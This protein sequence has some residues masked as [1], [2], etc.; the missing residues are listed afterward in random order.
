MYKVSNM[1]VTG[2]EKEKKNDSEYR[3]E[4]HIK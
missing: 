1:V 3:K 2:L 4:S